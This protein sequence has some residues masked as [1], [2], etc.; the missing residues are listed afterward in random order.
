MNLIRILPEGLA[1][2]IAAGEV[3]ERPSSVVKELLENSIDSAATN[4]EI[5]ISAG[6]K[7]RIKV[8]DNGVGMG[9]EDLALCVQRHATSKIACISDLYCVKTLGFRGEA[10]ASIASVAR[11][12]IQSRPH[13]R[14]EGSVISVDGGG[15]TEVGETGCPAGTI[16][17]VNDL[18]FNV[19]ARK[20]FLKADRTEAAHILDMAGRIALPHGA[21]R[22]IVRNE[23][24]DSLLLPASDNLITRIAALMGK[25]IAESAE[26]LAV[27]VGDFAMSVYL[28]PGEMARQRS[29]GVF[30][31]LNGRYLRDRVMTRAILEGYSGRLLKGHYP[32]CVL[33]LEV[34]PETVDVNVHPTKQEVRFRDQQSIFSFIAGGIKKALGKRSFPFSLPGDLSTLDR[35]KAGFEEDTVKE[36]V[37]EYLPGIFSSNPSCVSEIPAEKPR[38]FPRVIGQLKNTYI[39]CEGEEGLILMDQHAAHERVIFELMKRDI[40]SGRIPCQSL[41]IPKQIELSF[42]E[43]EAAQ[44][45]R[46]E[47]M[48]LGF[49]VEHFGGN[50]FLLK[51]CPAPLAGIDVTLCISELIK[52]MGDGSPSSPTFTDGLLNTMACHAAIRGNH[53]MRE[54]EMEHLL[55]QLKEVGLPANCPHGRPIYRLLSYREL[56]KMFKRA[57]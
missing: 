55:F 19:P 23:A 49:D 16:V 9:R 50:S 28:C 39:L 17:E 56:E 8:I 7:S 42:K 13:D 40:S 12:R 43:T 29:D 31:Y 2:Q 57:L 24:K 52:Q 32:Y 54:E 5:S 38:A 46:D 41:L 35:I 34:P 36:P 15:L 1:S 18:F 45:K 3:V 47:L 33:F 53:E 51:A 30:T 6:G 25:D 48:V 4:I 37:A 14:L 20:K 10:L 27:R 21:V 11:L 26:S 44:R 22:L